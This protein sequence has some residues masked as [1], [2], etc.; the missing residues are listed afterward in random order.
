[1]GNYAVDLPFVGSYNPGTFSKTPGIVAPTAPRRADQTTGLKS[2]GCRA[3]TKLEFFL[4]ART[5]AP[6][7]KQAWFPAISA[8]A[9]MQVC[10]PSSWRRCDGQ[11]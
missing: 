8:V 6:C 7:P 5:R 9:A 3:P 4:A 1:M 11:P 2:T 10:R